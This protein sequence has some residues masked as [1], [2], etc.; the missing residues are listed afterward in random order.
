VVLLSFPRY[1]LDSTA[2]LRSLHNR[3]PIIGRCVIWLL[4]TDREIGTDLLTEVMRPD[5]SVCRATRLRDE[6]PAFDSRQGKNIFPYAALSTTNLGALKAGLG[7]EVVGVSNAGVVPPL[8][9]TS[10]QRSTW[11]IEHKDNFTSHR[12]SVF[13]DLK[14]IC[15]ENVNSIR[16]A[17]DIIERWAVLHRTLKKKLHGLSPR[18]NYP[19]RATA[20]CRRSDCQLLRIKGATWSAWR[21]PT[22][23]LS[24]F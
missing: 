5:S 2:I 19:D 8:R 7:C 14:G 21:I 6:W 1:I 3:S 16:L 4:T 12:R 23:V 17:Q 18:A 11:L 20:A 9:H 13:V 24:V 15:G 10:A 22:A